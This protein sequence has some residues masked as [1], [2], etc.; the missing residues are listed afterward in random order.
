MI[1]IGLLTNCNG[2]VIYV[3]DSL[4]DLRPSDK[5]LLYIRSQV[6]V[7]VTVHDDIYELIGEISS[8]T[9]NDGD[10]RDVELEKYFTTNLSESISQ[11]MARTK[12]TER[13]EEKNRQRYPPAKKSPRKDDSDSSIEVTARTQELESMGHS[14]SPRKKP[15]RQSQSKPPASTGLTSE[16]DST[17]GGSSRRKRRRIESEDDTEPE[18]FPPK[19]TGTGVGKHRKQLNRKPLRKI[20]IQTPQK[21]LT[22]KEMTR[23]WNRT[24]RLG[25]KSETAQGWLKKTTKK[26]EGQQQ[27]LR[28]VAPGTRAL[29]EIRHYQRC[30]TFLIAV[31]PFQWLMQELTCSSLYTRDGLRWQSNAL[32]TLQSAAEAYMAGY[33]H[34]VNLCVLHCKVKTINRQDIWLAI[35]I[36]GRE[37]VGGKAQVSDVGASNVS[38]YTI[39]DAWEKKTVP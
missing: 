13:K 33:F 8:S 31:L 12:Q 6:G 22:M 19:K 18:S 1:N 32:F 10:D 20:N 9:D 7:K 23:E 5:D 3:E 39:A 34:D 26:R 11:V 30:R 24:G 27:A 38:S 15:G 21:G 17:S 28:K 37:H 25:L 35:T 36:R 2:F 4:P 16:E 14:K 29:R